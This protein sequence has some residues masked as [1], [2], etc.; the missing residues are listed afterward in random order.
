MNRAQTVGY[1][2]TGIGLRW[3]V[4]RIMAKRIPPKRYQKSRARYEAGK[5]KL[6][7]PESIALW[8]V[9]GMAF[10]PL[11]KAEWLD[12]AN[13]HGSMK[14]VLGASAISNLR[15]GHWVTCKN[16]LYAKRET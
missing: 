5:P 4:D 13:I 11:T 2:P 7:S 15:K 16:G 9:I 12:A 1:E 14:R 10:K 3:T 6:R 8:T